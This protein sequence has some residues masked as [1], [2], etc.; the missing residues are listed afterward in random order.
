MNHVGFNITENQL[1]LVEIVDRANNYFLENVDEELFTEKLNF[2]SSDLSFIN[3][4][5]SAFN[6]LSQRNSFKSKNNSIALPIDLF[7]IFSF[8][9]ENKLS[10]NE[11]REQIEWEFSILFPTLSFK[12]HILREKRIF[13]GMNLHPEILVIAIE[14]RIIKAIYDFYAEKNLE[15][16]FI[17]NAH[18][19]SDL[20]IKKKNSVSL[21]FS[22]NALSCSVYM[23]GDL[24]GFRKFEIKSNEKLITYLSKYISQVNDNVSEF[25]LSGDIEFDKIKHELEESLKIGLNSV[26]PFGR[27]SLSESFIQNEHYLNR[28]NLFASAAGISF[29]TS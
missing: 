19:T 11:L 6:N 13:A 7:R 3:I 5:H 20:L 2:Q 16:L 10:E 14:Q 15:L 8:P 18:F 22:K 12:D 29:R 28:A 4:L 17:D 25:Y 24:T 9:Y 21:Y 27:I 1:Q 23:N 26:N